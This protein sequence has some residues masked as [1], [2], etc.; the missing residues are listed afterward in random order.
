MKITSFLLSC[1]F[2]A[3]LF[4]TEADIKDS[5]ISYRTFGSA[6]TYVETMK[7]EGKPSILCVGG[8][9]FKKTDTMPKIAPRGR[10]PEVGE[11][12]YTDYHDFGRRLITPMDLCDSQVDHLKRDCLTLNIYENYRVVGEEKLEKAVD[13]VADITGDLS[14]H[15]GK[16]KFDFIHLE[17]VEKATA[18]P[19]TYKNV[20]KYSNPGATLIIDGIHTEYYSQRLDGVY[21]RS[22]RQ[23]AFSYALLDDTLRELKS[24][25]ASLE[26]ELL[27][28]TK[29]F[30]ASYPF[31]F[32]EEN[33]GGIKILSYY[34]LENGFENITLENG[35]HP[36][37]GRQEIWLSAKLPGTEE[38]RK[39]NKTLWGKQVA[40][41]FKIIGAIDSES[42]TGDEEDLDISQIRQA[43][44]NNQL[45]E[46][47]KNVLALEQELG[48]QIF[49]TLDLRKRW[50]GYDL[51]LSL[52]GI[53]STDASLY[54]Y[55]GSIGLA[56][57]QIA[58][59]LPLPLF[60]E[61]KKVIKG[62][63]NIYRH[64]VQISIGNTYGSRKV[65]SDYEKIIEKELPLARSKFLKMA[66]SKTRLSVTS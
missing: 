14:R 3:N 58:Q 28:E 13:I 20:L 46:K 16:V 35:K 15:L 24:L 44:C 7:Q 38:E 49:K 62:I 60:E 22:K 17:W 10:T 27:F 39:K 9:H 66:I 18:H 33:L 12:S 4:A 61:E 5:N 26:A 54:G 31:G 41:L 32:K 50:N 8:A 52:R 48:E 65:L 19:W 63:G 37:N 6:Q 56:F 55:Q 11:V 40:S 30:D 23:Y 34:L 2:V 42:Y 53:T 64:L 43:V 1:L 57:D 25:G 29:G 45:L 21:E 36:I 47:Y 59:E 51:A